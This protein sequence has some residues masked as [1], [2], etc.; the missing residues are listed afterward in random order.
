[1][2]YWPGSGWIAV[3]S[4]IFCFDSSKELLA[5]VPC[6]PDTSVGAAIFAYIGSRSR[7][8]CEGAVGP[9]STGRARFRLPSTTKLSP[10]PWSLELHSRA[11]L[12]LSKETPT[13]A[14]LFACCFGVSPKKHPHMLPYLPAALVC[15]G[16][17]VSRNNA[18][19]YA[20]QCGRGCVSLT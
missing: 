17:S 5:A 11:P 6:Y 9:Y 13:H 14:P 8:N 7:P 20:G 3:L 1:M 19:R 4:N 12:P 16:S 18:D 2:S 15:L 10:I